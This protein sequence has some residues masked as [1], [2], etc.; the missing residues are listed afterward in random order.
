MW[1]KKTRQC[2]LGDTFPE[3]LSINHTSKAQPHSCGLCMVCLSSAATV[4]KFTR[5]KNTHKASILL[6]DRG[7]EHGYSIS[8]E[9]F[10]KL[11]QEP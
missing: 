4:L 3:G 11:Y 8:E 10:G 2:Y 7:R 9:P 1:M 6:H 5:H